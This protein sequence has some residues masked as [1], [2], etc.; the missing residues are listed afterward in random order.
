MFYSLKGEL[1]TVSVETTNIALKI[2]KIHLDQSEPTYHHLCAEDPGAGLHS[3]QAQRHLCWLQAE[4][5][6]TQY[7]NNQVY[8]ASDQLAQVSIRSPTSHI[9][10]T[11]TVR[12][13]NVIYICFV[14]S[15]FVVRSHPVSFSALSPTTTDN[16]KF[17]AWMKCHLQIIGC[18]EGLKKAL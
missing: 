16:Q 5:A 7:P 14:L 15:A 3:L 9:H 2:W 13:Y 11:F 1:K 4:P 8:M 10:H 6:W 18:G 17:P 12:F